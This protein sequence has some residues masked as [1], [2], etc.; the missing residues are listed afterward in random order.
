MVRMALMRTEGEREPSRL[1]VT[2][3]GEGYKER[4]VRMRK[5]RVEPDKSY[6][7]EK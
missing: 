4:R 6:Q 5:R 1:T 7:R 3:K 2:G